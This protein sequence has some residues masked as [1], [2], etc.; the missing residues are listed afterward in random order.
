MPVP[1]GS[2]SDRALEQEAGDWF[3]KMRG[4]DADRHRLDFER[5]RAADPRRGAAYAELEQVWHL[6]GGLAGTPI[7]RA[8]HLPERRP[9]FFALPGIRPALAAI[10]LVAIVGAGI[11]IWRAPSEPGPTVAAKAGTPAVTRVGEIRTLKLSDGSTVTLD[12]DSAIEVAFSDSE[13]IVRLTRG[14]ARFDV[15]HDTGRPFMV[16]AGDRTV[17]AHGTVFDVRVGRDGVRVT[18][19]RGAVDVRGH[20]PGGG[21]P[22]TLAQLTPG[23]SFSDATGAAPQ[24][25][26]APKGGEQWVSG[27]LSFDGAPLAEVVD[28]ANR[29]SP[30]KLRLGSP[31]LASLRV[32]GAFR[33]LPTEELAAS[34]AA[35]FDLRVARLPDGDFALNAR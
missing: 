9:S 14:Q 4:P 8:R 24:V 20:A 30:H 31:A 21:K 29:Y 28:E 33:A 6:S 5:W 15:A 19:L 10:V 17:V 16:E 27:M 32:T 34:L 11:F 23:Q 3:A 22:A 13:R 2:P 7:G 18:L 26:P 25:A 35:A 12:T 1:G